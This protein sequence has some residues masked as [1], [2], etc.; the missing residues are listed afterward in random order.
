MPAVGI[1]GTFAEQ[2][3]KILETCSDFGR[4][5]VMAPQSA[6]ILPREGPA[7]QIEREGGDCGQV[8]DAGLMIAESE[9]D[10]RMQS[11]LRDDSD[12]KDECSAPGEDG[13]AGIAEEWRCDSVQHK[14]VPGR[15]CCIY[16]DAEEVQAYEGSDL[17][18]EVQGRKVTGKEWRAFEATID[19]F[20]SHAQALLI[21]RRVRAWLAALRSQ[22]QRR[23]GR[24]LHLCVLR[25]QA[26]SRLQTK[27]RAAVVLQAGVRQRHQFGKY[28]AAACA[29]RLQRAWR[30]RR[31]RLVLGRARRGAACLQALVRRLSWC[32]YHQKVL[33][34]AD[35]LHGRRVLP[36]GGADGGAC[37]EYLATPLDFLR[38]RLGAGRAAS[39][40]AFRQQCLAA[41]DAWRR[42]GQEALE[43]LQRA[44]RRA[45]CRRE[46]ARRRA[47]RVL[48]AGLLACTLRGRHARVLAA[49]ALQ[50]RL[51]RLRCSARGEGLIGGATASARWGSSPAYFFVASATFASRFSWPAWRVSV[52]RVAPR[53]CSQAARATFGAKRC[54]AAVLMAALRRSLVREAIGRARSRRA[55]AQ[56][57]LFLVSAMRRRRAYSELVPRW[58]RRLAARVLCDAVVRSHVQM[59]S[60]RWITAGLK[61]AAGMAARRRCRTSRARYV[62]M[63]R[64][65]LRL[66]AAVRR[67]RAGGAAHRMLVLGAHASAREARFA[68]WEQKW[69]PGSAAGGSRG[70]PGCDVDAVEAQRGIPRDLSGV[71]SWTAEESLTQT[72]SRAVEVVWNAWRGHR[73]RAY[74]RRLKQ[75]RM[76][77]AARGVEMRLR[78]RRFNRPTSAG[79]AVGVSGGV[80]G[81]SVVEH[82]GGTR[83]A[84]TVE[85]EERDKERRNRVFEAAF[86]RGG[87]DVSSCLTMPSVSDPVKTDEDASVN[88]RCVQ[89]TSVCLLNL[90]ARARLSLH[91][92]I[93]MCARMRK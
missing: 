81:G 36:V 26:R 2:W 54:A 22:R 65:A 30:G 56:A 67:A 1:R 33:Y 76:D 72:Q 87:I 91:Q 52:A 29:S 58:V 39:Q 86:L 88:T 35:C 44:T 55:E 38:V 12:S 19:A 27:R 73:C 89:D 83:D 9:E 41:F 10:S 13:G 16:K 3:Q 79:A 8:G 6:R 59:S 84:A 25:L 4:H 57:A 20:L 31:A 90:D 53:V 48:A 47:A 62:G 49:L 77:E 11:T 92:F 37:S 68:S 70:R 18:L 60:R 64:A 80:G 42:G 45:W 40:T 61:L 69:F 75:R 14:S 93:S 34:Y 7:P 5:D 43:L 74:L 85:E 78:Q 51:R 63:Q 32:G 17:Q 66:Q 82:G 23:A 24:Q 21:Q 28:S 50:A 46:L 71:A 15:W